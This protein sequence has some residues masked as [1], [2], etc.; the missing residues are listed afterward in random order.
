MAS[1]GLIRITSEP[2]PARVGR[3]GSRNAAA[4]SPHWNMPSSSSMASTAPLWRA[5]LKCG[6]SGIESSETKP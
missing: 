4:Y 3:N 1:S 6:S 5:A 2:S